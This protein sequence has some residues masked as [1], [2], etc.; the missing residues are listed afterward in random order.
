MNLRNVLLGAVSTLVTIIFA[1]ALFAIANA[2]PADPQIEGV[3]S[4][5]TFPP[6]SDLSLTLPMTTELRLRQVSTSP[7]MPN[8]MLASFDYPEPPRYSRNGGRSWSPMP[9][10]PW[11]SLPY[12]EDIQVVLVPKDDFSEYPRFLV[13]VDIFEENGQAH[14]F[15]S[16]DLGAGWYEQILEVNIG[17]WW[18]NTSAKYS[19]GYDGYPGLFALPASPEHVY[20]YV[21]CFYMDVI[22]VALVD[23]TFVSPDHGVTWITTD[24]LQLSRVVASPSNPLHLYGMSHEYPSDWHE[25]LDGGD[26]WFNTSFGGF[27]FSTI[28]GGEVW[29]GIGSRSLDGGDTWVYWELPQDC[30]FTNDGGYMHGKFK[31]L[32]A[33]PTIPNLLLMRCSVEES[34][35]T[36][37]RIMRSLDGGDTWSQIDAPAGYYLTLDQGHPGRLL[38]VSDCEVSSPNMCGGLWYSDDGGTTWAQLT[39]H[40]AELSNLLYLPVVIR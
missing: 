20:A 10:T 14:L 28:G 1:L 15:R 12:Y 25:S 34:P 19:L 5:A 16:G 23:E 8:W 35:E 17:G 18:C 2:A 7:L 40:F 32:L 39:A 3:S 38:G 27:E 21:Y 11:T 22:G 26:T 29:Y 33:H 24:T 31:Q 9:T 30:T 36:P 4:P 37:A 6:A 13:G